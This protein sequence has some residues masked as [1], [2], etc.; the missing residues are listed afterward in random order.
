MFGRTLGCR[1]LQI[2]FLEQKPKPRSP[3]RRMLSGEGG[4]WWR[5]GQNAKGG[6]SSERRARV[7]TQF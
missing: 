3:S 2:A 4:V 5:R 6:F 7:V 1:K